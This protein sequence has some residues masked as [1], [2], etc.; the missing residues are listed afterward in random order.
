[1]QATLTSAVRTRRYTAHHIT[2]TASISSAHFP[3][4]SFFFISDWNRSASPLRGL[5]EH[6]SEPGAI[7][8]SSISFLLFLCVFC[9]FFNAQFTFRRR[10]RFARFR[11]LVRVCRLPPPPFS[12][13]YWFLDLRSIK[14]NAIKDGESRR[15]NGPAT[16]PKEPS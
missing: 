13:L 11:L 15:R 10:F 2:F 3:P 16:F 1:M 9:F 12:L 7:F 14:G 5:A 8:L 4:A 6:K